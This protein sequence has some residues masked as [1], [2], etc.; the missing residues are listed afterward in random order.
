MMLLISSPVRPTLSCSSVVDSF[1]VGFS[2]AFPFSLGLLCCGF[3]PSVGIGLS[4]S[5]ILLVLHDLWLL[6]WSPLQLTHLSFSL[7]GCSSVLWDL[8]LQ[9][10]HLGCLQLDVWC[11]YMLHL[12]HWKTCGL[13]LYRVIVQLMLNSFSC[14]ISKRLSLSCLLVRSIMIKVNSLVRMFSSFPSQHGMCHCFMLL[15]PGRYMHNS[16]C[17]MLMDMGSLFPHQVRT[18]LIL[19]Q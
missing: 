19:M 12:V 9:S 16:L 6:G 8:E 17:I 2:W 15:Y 5:C 13:S 11:E 14:A 4:P 3:L 7:D 10:I 18:L 1:P